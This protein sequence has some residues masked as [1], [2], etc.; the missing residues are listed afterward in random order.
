MGY[1]KCLKSYN[2]SKKVK[3][4]GE[5]SWRWHEAI[6]CLNLS[7]GAFP[8]YWFLLTFATVGRQQLGTVKNR[9][10][11]RRKEGLRCPTSPWH[12]FQSPCSLSVVRH[13][14]LSMTPAI[15]EDLLL[16]S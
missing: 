12:D 1:S 7:G 15:E 5:W 9:V 8:N 14:G 10:I 11:I 3:E 16:R 13:D 4:R 2:H 6:F